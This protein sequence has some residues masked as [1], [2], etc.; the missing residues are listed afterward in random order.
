MIEK[1]NEY[2]FSQMERL[3]KMKVEDKDLNVEIE[4]AKAL[5][6][7]ASQVISG[8]NSKIRMEFAKQQLSL[9]K[10]DENGSSI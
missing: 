1:L 7:T 10:G 6:L 3:D 2:L 8:I 9:P 4:R 5:A